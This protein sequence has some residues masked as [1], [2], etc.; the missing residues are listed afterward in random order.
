MKKTLFTLASICAIAFTSCNKDNKATTEN[1]DGTVTETT[2]ND[3]E[4]SDNEGSLYTDVKTLKEAEES[5]KNLPKFKGKDIKIFQKIYFYEDG[6]I[7]TDIQDPSNAENIDS[8]TFKDG[9]WQEPQAVQISGGG[10]LSSNLF[11]LSEIKFETL[12]AIHSEL[13]KQSKDV[14]GAEIGGGIF[15]NL[16]V[17]RNEKYWIAGVSGTRGNYTGHFNADG[18][19][20]EFKKN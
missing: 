16:N 15:Y 5:L 10:D 2:S 18:T 14:E 17:I 7:V 6:R 9:K 20:K 11:S 8:Y 4:D 13:K 19:L 1:A 3:N 12:A